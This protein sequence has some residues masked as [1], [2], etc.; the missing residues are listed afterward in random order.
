MTSWD[1]QVMPEA[2]TEACKSP[3]MIGTFNCLVID[4]PEPRT[5]ANFYESLLGLARVEDS[6]E[7]VTL[8]D[9]ETATKSCLPAGSRLRCAR[10][11]NLR[12]PAAD[13]Y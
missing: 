4:C 6:D 7:W 11:A 10:L 12:D 8:G 3:G 1:G 9:S 13:A 5:L 2:A